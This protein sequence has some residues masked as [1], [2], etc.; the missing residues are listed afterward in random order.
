MRKILFAVAAV[1]VFNTSVRAQSAAS[2]I[3]DL[4]AWKSAALPCVAVWAVDG[5]NPTW[6]VNQIKAGHRL[7][8]SVRLPLIDDNAQNANNAT[9]VKRAIETFQTDL[10]WIGTNGLPICLRTN[11]ICDT[12]TR[13]ARQR[14]PQLIQNLPKSPLIWWTQAN[15]T[16]EDAPVCDSLAPVSLWQNEGKLWTQTLYVQKLQTLIKSPPFIVWVENNEGT[17]DRQDDYCTKTDDGDAVLKTQKEIAALSIRMADKVRQEGADYTPTDLKSDVMARRKDHYAALYDAFD[18]NL[19]AG[20][21]D[22][23]FT[24]GYGGMVRSIPG[25]AGS[26]LYAKWGYTG[27]FNC[28]DAMSPS[29]YI[30]NKT[31]VDFTSPEHTELLNYIPAW[32]WTE[33]RNPKA[34]REIS[35]SING[36]GVITGAVNKR[37]QVMTPALY[38]GWVQWLAWSLHEPGRSL[39]L[40]LYYSAATMPSD[41]F[42][43][44]A[45]LKTLDKLGAKT[46]KN[47][48][49]E[50]YEKP[51][52]SAVD[53][54]CADATLRGFWGHGKAV[55]SP[56]KLPISSRITKLKQAPFP[57]DDAPDNRRRYLACDANSD[58]DE[59]WYLMDAKNY[60]GTYKIWAVAT[61]W[62]GQFLVYVWTPCKLSTTITLQVPG[63]GAL[64]V[65]APTSAGGWDYWLLKSGTK[66]QKLALN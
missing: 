2:A 47:L 53:R 5:H 19:T 17:Y 25:M 6:Q 12:F 32:E 50:D 21:R 9:L 40:R 26:G 52:M 48:R 34:Y 59:I 65:A 44:S 66:P 28:Y 51:V 22:R 13:P 23:T 15:A 29:V 24:A 11:N 20:W 46:L 18:N 35:L 37:H 62:N 57:I 30:Q 63:Y 36:S 58:D 55:V 10:S 3:A 42:F 16:F 8:P 41:P 64:K 43:K 33:A 45:E 4:K 27:S 1:L 39:L 54:I 49:M 31:L 60:T 38:E 61:E 14:V 7:L 56:G